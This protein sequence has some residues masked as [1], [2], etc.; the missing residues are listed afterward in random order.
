MRV[1]ADHTELFE[2]M[3]HMGQIIRR[4][5]AQSNGLAPANPANRLQ[6]GR[7]NVRNHMREIAVVRR[8]QCNQQRPL[9]F[10]NSLNLHVAC[11]I[12]AG[13]IQ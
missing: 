13:K 2:M 10:L 9:G 7:G 1:S 5:K 6:P 8:P 4:Q 11:L 3:L 12:V